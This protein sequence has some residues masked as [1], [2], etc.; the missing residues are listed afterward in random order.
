M[1]ES[2]AVAETGTVLEKPNTNPPLK[3]E[4]PPKPNKPE[5]SLDKKG[6]D[7]IKPSNEEKK[8]VDVLNPAKGMGRKHIKL[9]E[10]VYYIVSVDEVNRYMDLKQDYKSDAMKA[11]IVYM[12]EEFVSDLKTLR[13]KRS[14]K[15]AACLLGVLF[16]L[17][18]LALIGV[19][20]FAKH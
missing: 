13:K 20:V 15:T 10:S 5:Q 14:I 18:I 16:V 1:A 9:G 2:A 6:E 12:H 8:D 3:N 19:M 11:F 7:Q 17:I 4:A